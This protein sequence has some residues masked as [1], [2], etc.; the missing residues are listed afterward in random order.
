VWQPKEVKT[1]EEFY[2]LGYEKEILNKRTEGDWERKFTYVGARDSSV[3]DY[4]VVNKE[5]SRKIKRFRIVYRM[6]LDY[7]PL[8]ERK[9]RGKERIEELCRME[10]LE[11][12]IPVSLAEK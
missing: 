6:D 5:M 11:E 7:L 1:K 9:K 8:Q 12:Q 10:I 2:R 3:I 4:A